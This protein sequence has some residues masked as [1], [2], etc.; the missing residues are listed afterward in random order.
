[1]RAAGV[2]RRARAQDLGNLVNL[3]I[4]DF[5]GLLASGL[6][7]ELL[8]NV[9]KVNLHEN[10]SLWSQWLRIWIGAGGYPFRSGEFLDLFQNIIFFTREQSL[11]AE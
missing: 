6:R 1:M 4:Q 7:L 5:R 2:Q 11:T 9:R 10:G 8:L 3:V